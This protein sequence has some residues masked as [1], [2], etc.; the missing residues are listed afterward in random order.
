MSWLPPHAF[1]L[2]VPH[3]MVRYRATRLQAGQVS[4]VARQLTETD[5]NGRL[6]TLVAPIANWA[7]RRGNGLTR[8][9]M[10]R[11]ANIHRDAELPS[12][13]LMM[14]FEWPLIEPDD[15]DVARLARSVYDVSEYVVMLARE[16]GLAS[17]LMPVAGGVALHV[18]CHARAQNI[19]AKGAEML[20]LIPDTAVTAI[21]RCSGH[22]GAWGVAVEH[23]PLAMKVG[24]PAMR[25]L[26]DSGCATT[27]S[28]CPLAGAHLVQGMADMGGGST[29]ARH[30]IEII[31]RA[32][33]L[34]K[35]P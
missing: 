32:Y 30:P 16:H 25:Q 29:E 26:K 28:E 34:E 8:P 11:L 3:L 12:C 13:A 27:C 18:A 15:A 1:N 24:R 6:G 31:A 5:R 33:G 17:G 4:M 21:E 14:K 9:L 35:V 2:D 23:F 22:S 19:G 20:R 7:T 10:E